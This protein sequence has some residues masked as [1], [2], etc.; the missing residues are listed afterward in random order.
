MGSMINPNTNKQGPIRV[1]E[2]DSH[3]LVEIHPND[4]DRAKMIPGR[5]WDGKRV[6]W[7]YDK[8]PDTYTALVSE[9]KRDAPGAIHVDRIPHRP[10]SPQ[11]MEIEARYVQVRRLASG[12]EGIEHEYCASF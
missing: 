6:A 5:Q 7:V 12:I 11:S 2:D 10:V 4:R 1:T 9:F 3:F 8:T